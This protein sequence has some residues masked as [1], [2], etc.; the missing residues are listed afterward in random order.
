MYRNTNANVKVFAFN[1]NTSQPQLGDAANI[2]CRFSLDNGARTALNDTN[3]VELEDGYYLFDVQQTENNGATVDFFPESTT[4]N[5]QVIPVEHSRYTRDTLTALSDSVSA[6]IL[7]NILGRFA[8][9]SSVSGSAGVATPLVTVSERESLGPMYIGA[10]S[11]YLKVDNEIVFT[12]NANAKNATG[13]LVFTAKPTVTGAQNTI[14]I[15][16]DSSF[17][18]RI[19]TGGSFVA[20]DAALVGVS[21][22]GNPIRQVKLTMNARSLSALASGRFYFDIKRCDTSPEAHWIIATGILDFSQP[23]NNTTTCI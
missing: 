14:A 5:I 16:V 21:A 18:L 6:S 4:A 3:P 20:G 19:P 9:S 22:G 11:Q 17:G 2:T 13:R 15:Q 10:F 1:R 8:L 23:I 7:S 12:I